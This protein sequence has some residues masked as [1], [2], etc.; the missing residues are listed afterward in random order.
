MK[1]LIGKS[2]LYFCVS[3]QKKEEVVALGLKVLE[4]ALLVAGKKSNTASAIILS[5]V[6][7]SIGTVEAFVSF[8]A[9]ETISLAIE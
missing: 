1:Y 8:G 6:A 2:V 9:L 5:V 4:A 7:H 3:E